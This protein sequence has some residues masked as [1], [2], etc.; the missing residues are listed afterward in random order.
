MAMQTSWA[1]VEQFANSNTIALLRLRDGNPGG[2]FGFRQF[3]NTP[4][5]I[6]R[7]FGGREGRGRA[8]G[9]VGRRIGC[10]RGQVLEEPPLTRVRWRGS[11][12]DAGSGSA[13]GSTIS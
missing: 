7:R 9:R 2:S 5:R 10:G 4:E 8:L 11:A 3:G 13:Q 6:D 12:G 1:R